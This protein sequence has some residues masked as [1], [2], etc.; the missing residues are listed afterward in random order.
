LPERFR[1]PVAPS[2]AE[3]IFRALLRPNKD[4]AIV[5]QRREFAKPIFFLSNFLS[6][7]I[8]AAYAASRENGGL[9]TSET[10]TP[11]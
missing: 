9:G 2:A 4:T 1:G 7:F 5:T 11:F 10:K 8:T 6:K 3:T